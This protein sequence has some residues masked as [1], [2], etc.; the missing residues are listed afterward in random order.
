MYKNEIQKNPF[1]RG[2]PSE[3]NPIVIVVHTEYLSE[4]YEQLS[5]SVRKLVDISK[6]PF[7][8]LLFLPVREANNHLIA[9]FQKENIEFSSYIDTKYAQEKVALKYNGKEKGILNGNLAKWGA[10]YVGESKVRVLD[11]QAIAHINPDYFVMSKDDEFYER[12]SINAKK[13][14]INELLQ[15]L[16]ILLVYYGIF[17][18]RP[19]SR[20]YGE[21]PYYSYRV[22]INFPQLIESSIKWDLISNEE[23]S[24]HPSNFGSLHQRLYLISKA[25]DKIDFHSLKNPNNDTLDECLY[26]LGYMIMLVTGAFDGIAWIIKDFYKFEI[27]PQKIS[28]QVPLKKKNTDFI[29]K[30]SVFNPKLYAFL[31]D[32]VTQKKINIIYQIRHSLQHRTF[33]QGMGYSTSEKKLPNL[34]FLPHESPDLFESLSIKES[35]FWGFKSKINEGKLFD[36]RTFAH[37]IF[38]VTSELVNDSLSLINWELSLGSLTGEET[39]K[40]EEKLEDLKKIK[41]FNYSVGKESIYFN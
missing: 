26:H 36:L 14:T 2:I 18:D 35:N 17:Y 24:I 19:N 20:I 1:D 5:K 16:R 12:N 25:L 11:S 7:V 13:I 31:L 9:L 39:K 4:H 23:I 40:L 10:V 30:L 27:N 22:S 37:R 8:S 29:K 38:E 33:I 6:L 3:N 21:E 28:I 32:E 41:T 34:L 15:E